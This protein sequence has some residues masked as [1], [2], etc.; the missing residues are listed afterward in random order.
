MKNVE[1]IFSLLPIGSVVLLHDAV[2][3]LMI[4]GVCQTNKETQQEYDYIGRA[5]SRRKR[6][7]G[8]AVS[9]RSIRYQS[10]PFYWL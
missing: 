2:K 9:V 3:P 8:S 10:N 4:Y 5:L 6:R 1:Q 7:F